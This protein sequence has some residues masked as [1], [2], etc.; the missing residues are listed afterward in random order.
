MR[1]CIISAYLRMQW[2]LPGYKAAAAFICT[3]MMHFFRRIL[4]HLNPWRYPPLCVCLR[5]CVCVCLCV[6]VCVRVCVCVCMCVCVC[7][8]DSFT[9]CWQQSN[10]S[11]FNP[12]GSVDEFHATVCVCACGVCVCVCVCVCLCVWVWVY[13]GSMQRIWPT[14]GLSDRN[15]I[16]PIRQINWMPVQADGGR[17]SGSRQSLT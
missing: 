1:P 15:P 4:H 8:C 7:V 5:V 13:E 2:L 12:R 3:H 16:G 6:Y 14:D 10:I 11:I 9:L 17:S